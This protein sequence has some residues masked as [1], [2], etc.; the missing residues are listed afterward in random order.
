MKS[1]RFNF[2]DE[3]HAHL[4]EIA[5]QENMSMKDVIIL[6]VNA[7]YPTKDNSTPAKKNPVEVEKPTSKKSILDTIP[8]SMNSKKPIGFDLSKN[9]SDKIP[10]DLT[11]TTTKS[12]E[13]EPWEKLPPHI[14]QLIDRDN[15][16]SMHNH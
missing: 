8:N 1:T 5:H 11:T 10:P 3:F 16:N 15:Y 13:L 6:A 4:V 9:G 2:E 14:R 12:K 7:H